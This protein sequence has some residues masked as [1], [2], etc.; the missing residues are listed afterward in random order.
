MNDD[1]VRIIV[2]EILEHYVNINVCEE[3]HKEVAFVKK[4]MWFILAGQ[5]TTLVAIVAALAKVH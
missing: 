5:L 2:N 1:H 4:M 3:R